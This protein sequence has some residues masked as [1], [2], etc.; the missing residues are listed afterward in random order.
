MFGHVPKKK[1]GS[2][3]TSQLN[4]WSNYLYQLLHSNVQLNSLLELSKVSGIPLLHYN[5][6]KNNLRQ[7]IKK[8]TAMVNHLRKLRHG[9]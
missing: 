2:P 7:E 9:K 8:A 6:Q 4:A 3:N 1:R 5:K